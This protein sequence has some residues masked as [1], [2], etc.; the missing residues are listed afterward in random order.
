MMEFSL[1]KI[2]F[3]KY[4]TLLNFLLMYRQKRKKI[5]KLLKTGQEFWDFSPFHLKD[6]MDFYEYEVA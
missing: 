6:I 1:M 3:S 4:S 2:T 5:K